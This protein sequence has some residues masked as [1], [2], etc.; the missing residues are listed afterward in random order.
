MLSFTCK[1]KTCY[2]EELEALINRVECNRNSYMHTE[3]VDGEFVYTTPTLDVEGEYT[4]AHY[5]ATEEL[6]K[7]LESLVKGAKK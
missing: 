1:I 2:F 7:D 5:K 4:V 3:E 6:L